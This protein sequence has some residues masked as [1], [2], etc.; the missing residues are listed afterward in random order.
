MRPQY[1]MF[2]K[3]LPQ[4]YMYCHE[5]PQIDTSPRTIFY[6]IYKKLDDENFINDVENIPFSV[7]DIFDDED[8]RLWGFSKLLTGVTDSNAPVKKKILKKPSVPYMNS[9]LRQAI[10]RKNMSRNAYK[11]GKVK[12]D[13]YRKQRNLTSAINK[14]SKLTYFRERC[15]GGP[16]NQSFWKTINSSWPSA[17]YMH[18]DFQC[19]FPQRLRYVALISVL[20]SSVPH[21]WG[22]TNDS[23]L[24][25]PP[26]SRRSPASLISPAPHICGASRTH[27]LTR[28]VWK[29]LNVV[30][31]ILIVLPDYRLP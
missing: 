23:L 31:K 4:F 30:T 8:D 9:R 26:N 2:L 1:I 22:V 29:I 28:V 15:D 6:R 25:S 17:T 14:Q 18:R 24:A 7:C 27:I 16:K 20:I 3:W 10:H 13:D 11:K 12:W 5:T 21:I 19:L